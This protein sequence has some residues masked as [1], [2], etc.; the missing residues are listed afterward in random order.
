[1]AT[2]GKYFDFLNQGVEVL[3]QEQIV[4]EIINDLTDRRGFREEWGRFDEE[5]KEEI[6]DTLIS[7]TANI[8][9]KQ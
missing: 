1:M 8:L 2:L 4:F 3:P 5:I 9:N 6:L 7:K